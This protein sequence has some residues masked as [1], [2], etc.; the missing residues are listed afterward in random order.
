M[1]DKV[2]DTIILGGGFYGCCLAL[3]LRRILR[4]RVI[5]IERENDILLRASYANQARV[6]NGYH[7][8]RSLLTA[9]RSR[10]NFL[11]FIKTFKECIDDGFDMYYAI[12]RNYS[13]IIASQ[14][15]LFCKRINAPIKTAPLHVKKL[16]DKEL[17]EDVF[18]VEE[19][20]FDAVKLKKRL[21][22]EIDK[23]GISLKLNTDANKITKNA[24]NLLNVECTSENNV[25]NIGAKRVFNCTYSGMNNLLVSSGLSPIPLK[26]EYTEMAIVDMPESLKK[27]GITVMCG[28]FFSIMPF[29]PLKL[30]SFSHVR[31]TPHCEWHDN[32]N[33]THQSA[34]QIFDTMPKK[35]KFN[36]MLKDAQRFIPDVQKCKY[37]K[38]I[39][40]IKTV[41]PISEVD[42]SRPILLKRNYGIKN[43]HCIMGAKIDNV[44]DMLKSEENAQSIGEI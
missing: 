40:E 36:H 21:A 13:K 6:H 42:D 7:Y 25:L 9:L 10:I 14:F 24:N 38:S 22:E 35:S 20:A 17:I 27:I 16:F 5:I 26:H 41:L 3:F 39:W 43:L 8:P 12:P 15:E 32:E 19:Y 28:P 1:N 23:F 44:F 11:P 34:Y 37:V 18:F 29:P 33:N 31:Y 2:Y 30:H 4:Q